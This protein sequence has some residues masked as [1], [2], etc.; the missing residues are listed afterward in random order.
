MSSVLMSLQCVVSYSSALL[1]PGQEKKEHFFSHCSFLIKDI[2]LAETPAD[3][4][5]GASDEPVGRVGQQA[6]AISSL[7]VERQV[8]LRKSGTDVI[9]YIV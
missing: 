8:L 6:T 1:Q 9:F 7:C 5:L 2:K 3:F 4:L